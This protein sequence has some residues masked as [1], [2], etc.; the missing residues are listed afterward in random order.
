MKNKQALVKVA[1]WLEAGAPH[2][3]VHEHS[4]G[5]FDMEFAIEGRGECGTACCIA[6]AIVQFENLVPAING[7][8]AADFFA[9]YSVGNSH[10]EAGVGE[11]AADHLGISPYDAKALFEPWTMFEYD[12][13]EEFSDPYRAA[14]VVRNY[15]E[16]GEVNW[17]AVP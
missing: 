1:E 6:G 13:Y 9:P 2:T 5:K 4:I 10:T 11:I 17:D 12:A 7:H 8:S 16:T 14:Q 3:T 15:L